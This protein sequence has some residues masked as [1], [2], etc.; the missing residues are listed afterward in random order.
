MP[1][2]YDGI[3]V[4]NMP[5]QTVTVTIESVKLHKAREMYGKTNKYSMG[6]REKNRDCKQRTTYDE[7]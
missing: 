1:P 5:P 6:Q 2:P 4:E 3:I 7:T